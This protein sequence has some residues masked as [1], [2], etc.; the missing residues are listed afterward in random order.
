MTTTIE[1]PAASINK[2]PA[3]TLKA[4]ALAAAQERA[5]DLA[6]ANSIPAYKINKLNGQLHYLTSATRQRK[7]KGSISAT[8]SSEVNIVAEYTVAYANHP[9]NHPAN[10]EVA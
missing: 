1:A 8:Y 4:K 5:F 3:E 2:L 10:Q 9:A 7:L 6:V